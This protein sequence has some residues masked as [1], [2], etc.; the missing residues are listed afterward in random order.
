MAVFTCTKHP[1]LFIVGVGKF[2]DGTL[3]VDGTKAETVRSV[4]KSGH[5]DI[6]EDKPKRGRPAKTES[7]K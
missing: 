4:A 3:E 2:N 7:D 6:T 5:F 1:S